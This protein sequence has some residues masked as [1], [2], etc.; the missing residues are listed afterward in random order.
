MWRNKQSTSRPRPVSGGW[1][2][3]WSLLWRLALAALL[4]YGVLQLFVR[5]NYFR[6]RVEAELSRMTGMEMRVG[7]IRAT[8]SLNL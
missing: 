4:V 7:R 5:T 2:V 1:R 6:L 3:L 8:E